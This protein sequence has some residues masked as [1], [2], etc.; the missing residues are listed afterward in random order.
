MDA[1]IHF[2]LAQSQRGVA[3]QFTL[4]LPFEARADGRHGFQAFRARIVHEAR[5]TVEAERGRV[6]KQ[7]SRF[8]RH[9][10]RLQFQSNTVC[11][12]WHELYP[13]KWANSAAT[14]SG[15]G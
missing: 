15:L 3:A 2:T 6:R 13:V 8:D 4:Q 7:P 11:T 1:A 12:K 5:V 9:N 10:G 14:F